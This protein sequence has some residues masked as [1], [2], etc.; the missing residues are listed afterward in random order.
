MVKNTDFI[1]SLDSNPYKFG[2]YNISDISLLENDK[3][4]PNEGLSL[5][6]DHEKTSVI[7]LQ[8]TLRSVRHTSL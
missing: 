1:G 5:G 3:Q 6:M 2:H 4:V 7:A 8:D